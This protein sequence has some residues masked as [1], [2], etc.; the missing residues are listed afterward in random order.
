MKR[1]PTLSFMTA[2]SRKGFFKKLGYM[3]RIL[4]DATIRDMTENHL[5]ELLRGETGKSVSLYK[6][7]KNKKALRVLIY[8]IT[9]EYKLK[10]SRLK[11]RIEEKRRDKK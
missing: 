8:G 11:R 1:L 10:L 9:L 6:A 7:A 2:R 3:R 4:D 5:N